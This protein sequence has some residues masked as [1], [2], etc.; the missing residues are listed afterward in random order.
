MT[1]GLNAAGVVGIARETTLGTYVAPT[2]FVPIRSETLEPN[3]ELIERRVIRNVAG[4]VG[5]VPGNLNFEGDM[6]IE[7]LD[8][9]LP[10]FLNAG[11]T[12]GT[13]SGTGSD[14]TYVFTPAHSALPSRS[15][16]ITVVRNNIVFAYTACIVSSF[17]FT[18]DN[19]MLISRM[20]VIAADEATQSVPT[21]TWPSTA[22]YGPGQ[23]TIQIPTG[24]TVCDVDMSFSFSIE[25]NATPEF[26]LC[27]NRS[28]EFARFG[29]RSCSLSLARD[30]ETKTDYDNFKAT[31]PVPQDI[32]LRAQTSTTRGI[33]FNMPSTVKTSYGVSL[34]AQGDL[35]RAEIEYNVV[36]TSS[37]PEYTITINTAES[38]AVNGL[39]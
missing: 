8:D 29:E 39:V 27:G 7:A 25:D 14:F 32:T 10:Y 34:S 36:G 4:V 11:R 26:R 37:L 17:E 12:I 6:E 21:P 33:T 16:S 22:P 38:I 20:S 28:A 15:L 35:T 2:K 18:L 23:Y 1:V 9:V 5:I 13:K 31:P 30:F 19:G 3:N 24:T